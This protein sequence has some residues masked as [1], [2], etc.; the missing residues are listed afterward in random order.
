MGD[1]TGIE[2]ADSTWN[3]TTG[4]THLS[5]G[6][7]GCY[8]ASL[9]SGRLS[10]VPAYAGLAENGRFNGT[11]R[12]L[13]ERLD[14]PLRWTRPRMIFVDSMS[15][16]F[17][18]AIPDEYLARVFA[19]MAAAPRHTFQ[20]LTKR[21]ARMRSLMTSGD[22]RELVRDAKGDHRTDG[23]WAPTQLVWPLPNVWLGTS[24]ENQKWAD[25][26]IPALLET[27]AAVRFLSCEPL[28]GPVDLLPY[29]KHQCDCPDAPARHTRQSEYGPR[30]DWVIVG[31]ESGPSA[32]PMHP[33]WARSLRDQ[34]AA[35]GVAYHFKQWGEWAPGRIFGGPDWRV[36]MIGPNGEPWEN[37]T[38]PT[39][40]W[41]TV[42][43]KGKKAAGRM[44]DGR[45]WD[46]YPAALAGVS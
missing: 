18:D 1:R 28:L 30:P 31:G 17:H 43:R 12:L 13:P 44:L 11:V 2:W 33:S 36:A 37:D 7:D 41:A 10:H 38:I 39:P 9:A 22:F 16:L 8:A 5:E 27:R 35:V 46:E 40:A 29:L 45:T 4:C 20:V 26:R 32:R 34:C 42:Y 3:P 25:I 19:V 15:D 6:C 14:Q 21:P 24:V 23:S